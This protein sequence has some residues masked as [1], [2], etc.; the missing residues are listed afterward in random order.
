MPYPGY[1]NVAAP[2]PQMNYPPQQAYNFYEQFDPNYY[3]VYNQQPDP[4]N[5][6]EAEKVVENQD[7]QITEN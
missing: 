2:N 3:Q 4:S 1:Q 5:H 6:M 7:S